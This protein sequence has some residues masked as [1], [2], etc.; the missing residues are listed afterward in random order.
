MHKSVWQQIHLQFSFAQYPFL[1]RELNKTLH[2]HLSGN[3]DF[4]GIFEEKYAPG[5]SPSVFALHVD[6]CVDEY[7]DTCIKHIPLQ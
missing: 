3:S 4:I 5:L 7:L 1:F 6:V 2:L